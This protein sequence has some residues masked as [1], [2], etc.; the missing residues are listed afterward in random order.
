MG[1]ISE[2][3]FEAKKVCIQTTPED[4]TAGIHEKK[5]REIRARPY[6]KTSAKIHLNQNLHGGPRCWSNFRCWGVCVCVFSY[7]VPKGTWFVD[8]CSFPIGFIGTGMFSYIYYIKNQQNVGKYTIHGYYGIHGVYVYDTC[9]L[10]KI[11]STCIGWGNL[12]F[13]E[14]SWFES[15]NVDSRLKFAMV[16]RENV[17]TLGMVPLK[18]NPV[19]ILYSGKILGITWYNPFL[20]GSL[21]GLNS[22]GTTQG[23]QHF[24]YEVTLF[25]SKETLQWKLLPAS[26]MTT[27]G[28]RNCPISWF[29]RCDRRREF[30]SSLQGEPGR[31]WVSYTPQTTGTHVSFLLRGL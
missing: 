18:I 20:K 5:L 19:Y 29:N 23:Y 28:A 30:A 27:H 2:S 17:F 9:S 13:S 4:G 24:P 16:P 12:L 6:W 22:G 15:L 11:P 7:T 8:V 10:H 14:L 21:G 1:A 3:F 25:C 26:K 31:C